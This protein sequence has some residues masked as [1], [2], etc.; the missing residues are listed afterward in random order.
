[1]YEAADMCSAW[2]VEKGILHD[3]VLRIRP[4]TNFVGEEAPRFW[5]LDS[6]GRNNLV[7]VQ[8]RGEPHLYCPRMTGQVGIGKIPFGIAG[9]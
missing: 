7:F 6:L 2:T 9:G 8:G 4:D 1:M 3:T 5:G